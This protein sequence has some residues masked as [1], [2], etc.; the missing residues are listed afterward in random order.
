VLSKLL[1]IDKPVLGIDIG[2]STIK[3]MQIGLHKRRGKLPVVCYGQVAFNSASIIRGVITDF[4]DIASAVKKLFDTQLTGVPTTK[5]VAFCVPNEHSFGR[6]VSLP[7]MTEEELQ[8]AVYSEVA[9]TVPLK[10]E[11][12]YIDYTLGTPLENGLREVQ[13]V[14]VPCSIVDPYLTLAEI[15]G[16]EPV[17]VE[18]NIAAVSRVVTHAEGRDIVSM[19]IDLGST[20]ADLS[21]FDGSTVVVMK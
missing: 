3:V 16:L 2:R 12:L 18:T 10:T 7:E 5:R 19:I 1:Y 11:E 13:I 21:I 8:S 17:L 6:M 14:A 15:L 9:R 20:A 4:E